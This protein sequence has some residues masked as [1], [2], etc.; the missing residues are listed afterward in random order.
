MGL[1]VITNTLKEKVNNLSKDKLVV[2]CGGASNTG[3]NQMTEGLKYDQ[4]CK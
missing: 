1:E 2:V 3:K 4:L